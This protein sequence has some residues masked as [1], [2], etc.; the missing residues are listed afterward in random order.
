VSARPLRRPGEP[1]RAGSR[2]PLDGVVVLELGQILA[3]PY[4]GQLLAAFG[5]EVIKVEPPDG[6]DP[7]RTWR[8][9]D[10]DDGTSLWWRSL[11]RN[12]RAVAIDLA[13]P[14]GQSLVR[15][16][17]RQA[18]V[19]I[20]NFKPGTLE[21]WG[22]GPEILC[23]EN[24]ALVFARISGFGQTGPYSRRPGYASVCE[25]FGGLRHLTGTPGEVPVRSNVSL[26]DS[27][28]GLQAALG[29]LLA[30][31]ARE[32]DPEGRGQ[33]VDVAIFESVFGV[34]ESTLPEFDRLGQ[35]RGPS[36]TTITGVVPSNAY[37]SADG[38]Q[39]VIGANNTANYR[40][41]MRAAG[42]ADLADDPALAANPG[43][44][45]R[46]AEIDAALAAWSATLAADEIVRRLEAASVPASTIYTVADMMAD[47][48]YV[49][50]ELFERLP[51]GER[52]IA[53][54]TVGP[55]LE[56]TPARDEWAG[57][58]LGTDTRQILRTRLGLADSEI[59]ALAREGVVAETNA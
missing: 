50:R 3:G 6:G 59:D 45:A 24:P 10:P 54:P 56:R 30:L 48:H 18:D 17:A 31:R 11:G 25:A 8:G 47:P 2:R 20:E 38:R 40:R 32:R 1:E 28:A 13:V 12:K 27:L 41:L 21:Q 57:R 58:E 51:V 19:L 22:L 39:V 49:A 55:K 42:R 44:V 36:G 9:L 34:L 23:T 37:P 15:R 29:I 7:I 33:V 43:R 4:A 53:F 14:R 5:A 16:L 26:G 46:Q 52:E 35:V